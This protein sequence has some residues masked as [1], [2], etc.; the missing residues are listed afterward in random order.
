MGLDEYKAICKEY[1]RE[2]HGIDVHCADVG[3]EDPS[4]VAGDA[5]KNLPNQPAAGAQPRS[6]N[7]WINQMQT[8]RNADW[9]MNV[10]FEGAPDTVNPPLQ[11]VHLVPRHCRE[12]RHGAD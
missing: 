11:Q 12:V 6:Y 2:G 7:E 9:E 3:L 10:Q 1:P 8:S 4:T 5:L